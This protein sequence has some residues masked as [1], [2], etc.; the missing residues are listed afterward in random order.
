MLATE[1]SR[2][3]GVSVYS[4]LEIDPQRRFLDVIIRRNIIRHSREALLTADWPVGIDA[5][6][7]RNLTIEHNIIDVARPIR[8]KKISNLKC[9]NNRSAAG[10]LFDPGDREL[11]EKLTPVDLEYAVQD[12]LLMTLL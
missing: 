12:A 8:Y 11:V 2:P 5:Y 9:F 3:M 1:F 7:C 6:R 10:I 4:D